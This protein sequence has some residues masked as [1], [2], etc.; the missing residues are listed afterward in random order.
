MRNMLTP[1]VLF[2]AGLSWAAA[3]QTSREGDG[4]RGTAEGTVSGGKLGAVMAAAPEITA[5]EFVYRAAMEEMHGRH[6]GKLRVGSPKISPKEIRVHIAVVGEGEGDLVFVEK[7]NDGKSA[8]VVVGPPDSEGDPYHLVRAGDTWARQSKDAPSEGN[9]GDGMEAK[10]SAATDAALAKV[11]AL[12]EVAELAKRLKAEPKRFGA[13]AARLE[14]GP[15]Q[16]Q[17]ENYGFRFQGVVVGYDDNE[18]ARFMAWQRFGVDVATGETR[19]Y[20]VANDKY[21]SLKVW[22]ASRGNEER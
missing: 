15:S 3:A 17:H 11:M 16:E 14:E 5:V 2:L 6:G 21:V 1:V 19:V 22:R 20:D 8:T 12:P 7:E 9:E 10:A 13:P 18:L 4:V